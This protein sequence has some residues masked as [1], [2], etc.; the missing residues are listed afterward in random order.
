VEAF[1]FNKQPKRGRKHNSKNAQQKQNGYAL[2]SSGKRINRTKPPKWETKG[3]LLFSLNSNEIDSNLKTLLNNHE[4]PQAFLEA[5]FESLETARNE[6]KK[7]GYKQTQSAFPINYSSKQEKVNVPSATIWGDISVGPILAPKLKKAFEA[8]T[9][10]Q[11]AAFASLSKKGSKSSNVVIASPTGTG[12]TLSFILPIVATTKRDNCCSAMI[13][14]PTMDLAFQIQR[15]VDQLWD[16]DI[17]ERSALYVVTMPEDDKSLTDP[18]QIQCLNIAEIKMRKTPIIAGTPKSLLSMLS[19]CQENNIGIFNNLSTLVL[20]EADRLLHTD[21][22]AREDTKNVLL[23]SPTVQLIELLERMKISLNLNAKHR[24]RLVCASATI[25]RTLRRQIMDLTGSSSI[26]KAAHLV[27]ADCR[28]GKDEEKRKISLLPQTIRHN[29]IVCP[30]LNKDEYGL[31]DGILKT[32]LTLPPAPTLVF[33]GNVGVI[34]MADSLNEQGSLDE[35]Y[36]LRDNFHTNSV[37]SADS[38]QSWSDTPIFV[39]GEKF[40]RGLDIPGIKYVFLSSPPTTAATYTHLAGRTGRAGSDG[41]V[42][43]FVHNMS[44]AKRIVL[45]SK[46]LGISFSSVDTSSI[47]S[48]EDYSSLSVTELKKLLRERG[49]KVSGKKSELVERLKNEQTEI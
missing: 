44:D 45:L 49:L 38:L 12:K 15:V 4:C 23:D 5:Y 7:D 33:P 48:D 30:D 34:K 20:D 36:T 42:F 18:D 24:I 13:V 14:T 28:T 40:S 27:T 35:V 10:I 6:L 22:A 17:Q 1:A 26:D 16:L 31:V 39:V 43:T 25:G 21:L 19:Y 46:S 2:R 3:D 8:P 11:S 32:L 37:S 29:Y 9:P 41:T 47:E